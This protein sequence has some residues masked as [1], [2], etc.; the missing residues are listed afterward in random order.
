MKKKKKYLQAYL[1]QRGH[2]T[3]F[4]SSVYGLLGKEA[5]ELACM[6]ISILRANVRGELAQNF[7]SISKMVQAYV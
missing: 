7:F 5:T 4:V 1:D 6:S 2:F 3:P